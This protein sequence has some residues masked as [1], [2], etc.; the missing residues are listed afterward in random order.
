MK[1]GY[2]DWKHCTGKT[3]RIVKH[4]NSTKHKQAM[5][6]WS[7][8]KGNQEKQTSVACALDKQRKEEVIHNR[9]YL[10][11]IIELIMFCASQE[12]GFRGH[13]ESEASCSTNRGNFLEL[14]HLVGRHDPAIERRLNEGPRNA[15]HIA[16]DIQD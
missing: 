15:T 4:S 5:A 11:T 8:F 6:S 14:L 10:K 9:Y 3:G 12:I 13:R 1:T 7:D 16:H 2:R